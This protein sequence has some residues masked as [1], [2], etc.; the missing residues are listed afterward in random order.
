MGTAQ[1]EVVRTGRVGLNAFLAGFGA[2][3]AVLGPL[4]T[5]ATYL[6]A[7]CQTQPSGLIG[8]TIAL[9]AIFLPSA[10]LIMGGLLFGDRLRSASLAKIYVHPP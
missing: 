8:A 7:V 3:Q 5:F 1:A 4:F 10:L 2:V 6:G 9:L